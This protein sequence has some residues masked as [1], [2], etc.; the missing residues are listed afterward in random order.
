[1]RKPLYFLIY[2]FI[3]LPAIAT[4]EINA[5]QVDS[6]PTE[7]TVVAQVI[8]ETPPQENKPT[9]QAPM[10]TKKGAETDGEERKSGYFHPF[11]SITQFYTDNVLNTRGN[12][13]SEFV[14]ILSPAIW[15][16][17]PRLKVI[18]PEK[19]IETSN[20]APGGL[21]VSRVLKR[22]PGTYQSYLMYK[23]DY[24]YYARGMS[25]NFLNHNIQAGLQYNFKGG[26]SIDAVDQF[27][28]TH[29][30]RGTGLFFTLDKYYANLFNTSLTYETAGRF[31][32][33]LDYTNYYLH[34]SDD[35]NAFRNRSDNSVSAYV[36]YQL[37]TKTSLFAEYE[38]VD[39]SYSEN[40][41]SDSKEHHFF[42]GMQW[43]VTEKSKGLLKAGYGIKDFVN[44]SIDKH[45]DL[46]LEA[47]IEHAITAKTSLKITA[48][49]RTDESDIGPNP[50]VV[51]NS[52]KAEYLQWLRSK[53]AVAVNLEYMRNIYEGT[54]T[55]ADV[56]KQR[57]DSIYSAA[58]AL[59][60]EARKWL[61]FDLAYIY[62]KRN[63]NFDDFD[64]KNNTIMLRATATM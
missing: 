47:Q 45:S 3:L 23:A 28:R 35:F 2:F 13:E 7:N 1:M 50:F 63:S 43:K 9:E 26:M 38:Y 27:L 32:L 57:K 24:E 61:K 53:I 14:T 20:T 39:V 18:E 41:L 60:L 4:A 30:S 55:I 29:N 59:R 34:Y 42:G 25:E 8:R 36:F 21:D 17:L 48:K 44:P 11:F 5:V 22:Y 54:L 58:L 52:I 62:T 10:G 19:E 15:I 16:S 33:R 49:K 46:Y 31:R 56:T 12:R 40:I 64:Y 51:M 37:G 6:L